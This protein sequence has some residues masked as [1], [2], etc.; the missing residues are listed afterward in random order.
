MW[1]Y[2]VQSNIQDPFS[3]YI[4][5]FRFIQLIYLFRNFFN[6]HRNLVFGNNRL[7]QEIEDAKAEK[8]LELNNFE[9]EIVTIL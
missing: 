8:G 6:F 2:G 4:L 9:L 1:N 5:D 3:I 7:N